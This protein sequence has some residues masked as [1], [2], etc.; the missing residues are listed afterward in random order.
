MA[1]GAVLPFALSSFVT[2]KAVARKGAFQTK[3]QTLTYREQCD[4]YQRGGSGGWVKW[5]KGI[6]ECTCCDEHLVFYG[7][8]ESLI[9]TLET[10][11]TLYV[12]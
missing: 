3:K 7:S 5:M 1:R 11:I 12:N 2:S 6:K 4:G 10:S 8:V 9:C